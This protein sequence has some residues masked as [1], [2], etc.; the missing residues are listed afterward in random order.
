MVLF[1]DGLPEAW[2]DKKYKIQGNVVTVHGVTNGTTLTVKNDAGN[3]FPFMNVQAF[4]K[5]L[6]TGRI[7]PV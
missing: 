2:F 5:G 1:V 6:L 3:T 7:Q 4:A